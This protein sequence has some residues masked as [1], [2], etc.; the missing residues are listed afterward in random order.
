MLFQQ[1]EFLLTHKC[2]C[3]PNVETSQLIY[4]ANQLTSFYMRVTLA[5]N[6]L[7]KLSFH[8]SFKYGNKKL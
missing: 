1:D 4:T 7:I 6:G 2:L 5:F 3:C 8:R